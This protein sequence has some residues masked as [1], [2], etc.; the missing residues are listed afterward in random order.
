MSV[1][2]NHGRCA[3]AVAWV[4]SQMLC[5]PASALSR[6]IASR[7]LMGCAAGCLVARVDTGFP[8]GRA[9]CSLPPRGGRGRGGGVG[10]LR[11]GG[12]PFAGPHPRPLPTRGRGEEEAPLCADLAEIL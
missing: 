2:R 5:L 6:S 8:P 11:Q 3:G 4:R 12:A 7:A 1:S 10:R 9:F